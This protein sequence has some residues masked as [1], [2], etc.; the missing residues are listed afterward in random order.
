MQVFSQI[1]R[2]FS[3]RVLVDIDRCGGLD[4]A[5]IL[6]E[7]C[8]ARGAQ[9]LLDKRVDGLVH[10]GLAERRADALA[11]TEPRGRRI[12]NLGILLKRVIKPGQGG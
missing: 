2:G 4:L 10:W 3:L 6:R 8:D 7:Y 12:G 5:G 1:S 11:I 9:W